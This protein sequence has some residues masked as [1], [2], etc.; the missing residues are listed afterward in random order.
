MSRPVLAVNKL[1]PLVGWAVKLARHFGYGA[2][3]G[4]V[5]A[6]LI[7]LVRPAMLAGVLAGLA[8]WKASYDGW[9][10]TLGI[11][12]PPEQDER[13]RTTAM[14][15]AHLAYGAALGLMLERITERR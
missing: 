3:C 10:P 5:Y 9:I 7:G 13:G 2:A 6:L 1:P 11:M 4:A 14:V 15:L 8:V 12:P